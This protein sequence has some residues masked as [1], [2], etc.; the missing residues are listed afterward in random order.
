MTKIIK[1]I[2]IEELYLRC[3]KDIIPISVV[4][5]TKTSVPGY[6]LYR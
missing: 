6:R 3:E 2:L 1:I 5:V 4:Y